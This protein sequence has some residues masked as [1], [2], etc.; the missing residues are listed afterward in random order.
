MM[1]RELSHAICPSPLNKYFFRTLLAI[2]HDALAC[3]FA[4]LV[5]F[6]LRFNFETPR[7]YSD[8]AMTT[9]GWVALVYLVVLYGFGLYR[10]IWRFASLTDL[11]RIVI[12]VATA[13]IR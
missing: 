5:A 9:V 1:N 7:I 8:L 11:R 13:A 6:A 3:V 4:W 2:T 12:A 10:G